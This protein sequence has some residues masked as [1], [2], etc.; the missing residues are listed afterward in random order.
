[1]AETAYNLVGATVIAGDTLD[2]LESG[3]V[4][5]RDGRVEAIGE[6]EPQ[7]NYP[8]IDVTGCVLA[9]GLINCHTHLGDAVLQDRAYG[10]PNETN[11]LW[12]PD[13]LRF[14]W[15]EQSGREQR[16]AAMRASIDYMLSCGVIAFADF[17][18]N[19]SDGVRELREAAR[20]SAVRDLIYARFGG[21]PAQTAEE[22]AGNTALLSPERVDELEECLEVADGF[23]PVWANELTDAALEQVSGLVRDRGKRLAT[24]L[25]ES[26]NYRRLSVERTGST[27]TA[28]TLQHI[29]PDYV[30][31]MTDAT[32]EELDAVAAAGVPL[33]LCPRGQA[34]LGNGFSPFGR[35]QDRGVTLA[36][37]TDNAMLNPPD[38]LQEM[39]FMARVT[40]TVTQVR[41]SVHAKD[42][43]TAGTIGGARALSL[44]E[45]LGSI[46]AGKSASFVVFDKENGV[47]RYSTDVVTG[48]VL[49][50]TRADV[51]TVVVDGVVVHGSRIQGIPA[52]N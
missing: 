31:H 40:P 14:G 23:S 16:V 4:S 11:L 2:V 10:W 25:I 9:P 48:I 34:A 15:M 47:L 29:R 49:A 21:T 5:V 30:V 36:I 43:L 17:R 41:D 33:V 52:S 13:G 12:A 39:D 26:P 35:A 28:R 7:N 6:G 32:D 19:G 42:I 37:G 18:E 8:R 1:M 22:L 38:V 50:A 46:S 51:K 45:D 44:E 24:H 27:D 3:Y 20:D